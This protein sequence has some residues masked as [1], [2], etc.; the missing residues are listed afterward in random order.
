MEL[1]NELADLRAAAA[2]FPAPSTSASLSSVAASSS[3]VVAAFP[4]SRSSDFDQFDWPPTEGPSAPPSPLPAAESVAAASSIDSAS[5]GAAALGD[6]PASGDL[7][8]GVSRFSSAVSAVASEFS[9]AP[10]SSALPS[11]FSG[12]A[13]R[14]AS[15]A[16]RPGLRSANKITSPASPR[17]ES[18]SPELPPDEHAA[19][20]TFSFRL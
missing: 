18:R 14:D 15:P 10:E 6:G 9:A 16:A 7:A 2:P 12:W 4:L 13:S 19:P 5:A 1:R 20:S 3:D 17:F 8:P 11:A